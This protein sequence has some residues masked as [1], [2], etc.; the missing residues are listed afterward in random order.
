MAAFH[1]WGLIVYLLDRVVSCWAVEIGA[2]LFEDAR[3]IL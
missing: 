1:D 2:V 3:P